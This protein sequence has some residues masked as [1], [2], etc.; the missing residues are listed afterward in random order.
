M[1][2]NAKKQV[3]EI[4]G[5]CL[6]GLSGGPDSMC[7]LKLLIEYK[8][9]FQIAHIDHN[10][11]KQSSKIREELE[12]FAKEHGIKFHYLILDAA[13]IQK[14]N[15][16][17]KLRVRR[18]D[19]FKKIVEK[20]GLDYLLLGHQKDEEAETVIKRFFEGGSLLNLSGIKKT[21]SI[22]G[23]KVIRPLLKTSKADV[24]KYLEYYQIPYH[25]DPTNFGGGNLRAKMRSKLLPMIEKVFG[26]KIVSPI[27]DLADQAEDLQ[28]YLKK[29]FLKVE[30][31]AIKGPF[32][33]YYPYKGFENYIFIQFIYNEIMNLTKEHRRFIKECIDKKEVGKTLLING[34]KVC[35]EEEGVFF[36]NSNTSKDQ[37]ITK[38]EVDWLDFWKQGYKLQ[39]IVNYQGDKVNRKVLS[40]YH[41]IKKTPI[42]L[43]RLYP[44]PLTTIEKKIKIR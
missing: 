8:K 10:L 28:K 19:F 20:E 5:K 7:L 9:S 29:E 23:M 3:I 1:L 31:L 26:K 39:T 43:R 41:R 35:F 36:I 37:Y 24:I 40:E 13:S 2:Q 12:L 16:E 34:F 42:C 22:Y 14:K 32:G 33:I 17:D 44:I 15:L 6:L 21:S 30:R 11:Q 4:K 25:T 27:C 18:L 38:E